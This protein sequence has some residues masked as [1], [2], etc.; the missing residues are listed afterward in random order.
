MIKIA[1]K[2]FHYKKIENFKFTINI[3]L[4]ALFRKKKKT[5]YTTR[6]R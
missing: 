6:L 5:N 2:M 4:T 1:D 3:Y